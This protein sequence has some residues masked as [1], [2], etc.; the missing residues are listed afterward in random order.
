MGSMKTI[1]HDQLKDNL[2]KGSFNFYYKKVNGDLRKA[3]GTLDLGRIPS[4]SHPKG[5]SLLG[6]QTAFYDLEVGDWRSISS[7]KEIWT[8]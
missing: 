2:R 1:T 4:I 5:G 6:G 3:M 8:D 7:S